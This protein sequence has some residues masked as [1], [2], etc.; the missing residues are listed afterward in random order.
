M[1]QR[2]PGMNTGFLRFFYVDEQDDVYSI[3]F[4]IQQPL[5][6]GSPKIVS[7]AERRLLD[8]NSRLHNRA[9]KMLAAMTTIDARGI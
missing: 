5:A 7:V 1:Q 8:S 9:T 4:H 3:G 6:Y 2:L